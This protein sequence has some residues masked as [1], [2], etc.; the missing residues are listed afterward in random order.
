VRRGIQRDRP[1]FYLIADV[2]HV[3]LLGR[4]IARNGHWRYVLDT[5]P[6]RLL[7][8]K[9]KDARQD[10]RTHHRRYD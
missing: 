6:Q 7:F 8:A 3:D 9:G 5:D 4:L 1:L 10:D 2:G